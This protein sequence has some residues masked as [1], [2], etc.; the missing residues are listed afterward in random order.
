MLRD[1][2]CVVV[3]P[4]RNEEERIGRV[5]DTMPGFV[6]HIIVVDDASTDAT[7]E[8]V[9]ERAGARRIT[10]LRHARAS[11]VGGAIVDGYREALRHGGAA[12]DA[13]C[14]MAGD[15]QMSPDDLERV[16]TPIVTGAADYVKGNRF[17]APDIRSVMPRARYL[18]GRV[19]SVGTSI[20]VGH[21]IH[22]SQC[23]FTALSRAACEELD[24]DVVWRG[25]GYPNDV[26]SRVLLRNLRIT[27]VPVRPI[28]A[29]ENSGLRP[30][31]AAVVAAL[32]LRA[33]RHRRR[34]A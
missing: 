16:A 4:A 30:Y 13:F 15:G 19:F 27:E 28:Y 24:L 11:G 9:L 20:A 6:D 23:G 1:A 2:K 3:V 8:R 5:L 33:Y 26:I 21:P 34:R 29:G 12:R 18:A 32:I 22:D 31:H 7:G 14:V 25:Y 10:L 17:T